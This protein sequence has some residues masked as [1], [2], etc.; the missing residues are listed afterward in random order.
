MLSLLYLAIAVAVMAP[1]LFHPGDW[2]GTEAR[3]VQIAS[4]MLATGSWFVPTHGFEPTL[5]KPPLHYWMLAALVDTCGAPIWL[6]RA[7]PVVLFAALAR[8]AH[9]LV[10]RSHGNAAAWAAGLGILTAPLVAVLA[11]R[12]EIDPVFAAFTAASLLCIAHG[13]AFSRGSYLLAGGLLGGM[14]L[15]AKGPPYLL[16]FAGSLLVWLRRRR[17]QGLWWA[18][19]G[20]VPLPAAWLWAVLHGSAVT[21]ALLDAAV[22]ESVGRV[23]LFAWGDLLEVPLFLARAVLLSLPFGFF[24]FHE[25]RGERAATPDAPELFVRMSAAAAFGAVLMLIFFPAR[26]ARYLL[27][28][29]PLFVVAVSPSV[30]AFARMATLARSTRVAVGVAGVTFAAGGAIVP[31]LPVGYG[32][33]AMPVLF[34]LAALT[35]Y[36]VAPR[37]LVVGLM[38]LSP[39]ATWTTV[40]D[41]AEHRAIHRDSFALPGRVLAAAI[42]ARGATDLGTFLHVP[43]QVVLQAGLLPA[44][45]ELAR[46]APTQRWLL[47]EAGAAPLEAWRHV[48][49]VDVPL[50]DY[51]TRVRIQ[52]PRRDLL[53]LERR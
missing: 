34:A 6:L 18:L 32:S 28:A 16:F 42:D 17:V 31:W 8:L 41:V 9:G 7:P 4:E 36:P 27:P 40:A 30:V 53:L 1:G 5:V 22:V 23:G 44:G 25:Y 52:L 35:A 11:P 43:S 45:D 46:R 21:D 12:A 20:M 14:A 50:A 2:T 10:A 49:R 48:A 19:L 24:L 47:M 29:V 33:A 38:A 15:L 51:V 3:R 26:P 13:V 39:L 37:T